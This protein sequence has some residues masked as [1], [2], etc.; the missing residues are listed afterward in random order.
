VFWASNIGSKHDGSCSI[1]NRSENIIKIDAFF[2]KFQ[3]M[4]LSLISTISPI[5]PKRTVHSH[6]FQFAQQKDAL[7]SAS[8]PYFAPLMM[9]LLAHGSARF[10]K[11]ALLC[12]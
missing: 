10:K 12:R 6:H 8:S 2:L 11:Q 5:F 7:H 4:T 3:M 1:P 9:Q